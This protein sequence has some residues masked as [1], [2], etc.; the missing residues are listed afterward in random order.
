[1]FKLEHMMI[2]FTIDGSTHTREITKKKANIFE[3]FQE[4]PKPNEQEKHD[5]H[6]K[7]DKKVKK[8]LCLI[9]SV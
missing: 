3:M 2:K 8:C 9:F 6:D 4:S 7:H 5:K 1:M